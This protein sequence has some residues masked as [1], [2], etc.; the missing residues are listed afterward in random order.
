[1]VKN[2]LSKNALHF[3]L[4]F[5]QHNMT[6]SNAVHFQLFLQP[7]VYSGC[8][9]IPKQILTTGSS[10]DP[11]QRL[12]NSANAKL[13]AAVPTQVDYQTIFLRTHT[14]SLRSLS[15]IAAKTKCSRYI[16]ITLYSSPHNPCSHTTEECFCLK[17]RQRTRITWPI[18]SAYNV[19]YMVNFHRA[20]TDT[21]HDLHQLDRLG[22]IGLFPAVLTYPILTV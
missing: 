14:S 6:A 18:F 1:M 17:S 13:V 21:I 8:I 10:I 5:K 19:F 15:E 16:T 3:Q 4:F 22:L 9:W 7:Y 20:P 11:K 12:A 2:Y